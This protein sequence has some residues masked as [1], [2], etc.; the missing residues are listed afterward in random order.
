MVAV[1]TQPLEFEAF[2]A[3]YPD[4]GRRY[5]LIEGEMIAVLPTGL[6]RRLRGCWWRSLMWR[7]VGGD[8][9]I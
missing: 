5:E 8:V 2:L 7:F 3:Q 1:Q 9:R 6:M 4:D